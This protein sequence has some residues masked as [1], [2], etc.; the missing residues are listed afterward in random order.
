M[1]KRFVII[2]ILSIYLTAMLGIFFHLHYCGGKLES[3]SFFGLND[4][5]SCCGGNMKATDCCE[6]YSF[7]IKVDT[8]QKTTDCIAVPSCSIKSILPI[9]FLVINLFTIQNEQKDIAIKYHSPPIALEHSPLYI[10]NRI[11]LI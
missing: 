1:L 5:K 10:L 8:D 11:L 3:I 4:E 9:S 2:S 7:Y 6:N